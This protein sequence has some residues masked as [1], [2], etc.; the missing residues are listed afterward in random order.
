MEETAYRLVF[1]GNLDDRMREHEIKEFLQQR[2]ISIIE[3]D[4]TAIEMKIGYAFVKCL[5]DGNLSHG[6]ELLNRTTMEQFPKRVLTVAFTRSDERVLKKIEERKNKK[7]I[8]SNSLFVIGFDPLKTK[9][10]Y[11]E[12]EFES[13]SRVKFVEI[14]RTFAYVYFHETKDATRV[15]EAFNGKELFGKILTIEYSNRAST[16]DSSRKRERSR[17]R[18]RG[19]ER[20]QNYI[21]GYDRDYD[22]SDRRYSNNNP[23]YEIEH[24]RVNQR[25]FEQSTSNS[26]YVNQPIYVDPKLDNFRSYIPQPQM[27]YYPSDVSLISPNYLLTREQYDR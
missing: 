15:L 2:Q 8:P 25:N 10:H 21:R 17:S 6:I 11:L 7:Q 23:S 18:S 9:P 16:F 20:D 19:R 14:I 24:E 22:H 27:A 4:P 1:I 13:V 3:N 26:S 12:H 5:D